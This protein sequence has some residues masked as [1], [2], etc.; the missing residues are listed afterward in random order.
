MAAEDDYRMVV[1]SN[2]NDMKRIMIMMVSM[3]A[4]IAIKTIIIMT[5]MF[6]GGTVCRSGGKHEHSEHVD[7]GH[8]GKARR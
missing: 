5:V 7:T 3:I 6:M 8:C 1:A 2:E 4:V